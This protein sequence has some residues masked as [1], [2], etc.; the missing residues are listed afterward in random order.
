MISRYFKN[1]VLSSHRC[2]FS[3]SP[4]LGTRSKTK[5]GSIVRHYHLSRPLVGPKKTDIFNHEGDA[6]F[7]YNLLRNET[8]QLSLVT[9]PVNSGKSMLMCH[10][11]QNLT[12]DS[13]DINI[14]QVNM[15]L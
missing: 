14:L 12:N 2:R 5:P 15:S 8:P 3:G 7:L 11:I 6:L 4:A 13:K 9:G 10:V 1:S